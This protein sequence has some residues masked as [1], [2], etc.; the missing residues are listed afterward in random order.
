MITSKSNTTYKLAKS[1]DKKRNREKQG[2]FRIEGLRFVDAA[3]GQNVLTTVL[4]T[5]SFERMDGAEKLLQSVRD[6]GSARLLLVSEDL[7]AD[8]TDTAS[9]QGVIGLAKIP[10]EV[11]WERLQQCQRLLVLDRLQ[12]PG[13]LGTIIRAADAGGI[14]GIIL[15]KGTVDPYNPKVL[16][17]TMGSLFSLPMRI[18]EDRGHVISQLNQSGH[19]I[20]VTALEDAQEYDQVNLWQKTALVIGNEASGVDDQFMERADLR[21]TIPMVG[22]AES[23]NAAVAASIVIFEAARQKRRAIQG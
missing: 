4:Y 3:L 15:L 5:P 17:S 22:S 2:L 11:E 8:L 13:N 6:H 9:P 23:L 16:R 14:D 18:G 20:L 10:R 21:I 19:Q 12:D 7:L 1:L